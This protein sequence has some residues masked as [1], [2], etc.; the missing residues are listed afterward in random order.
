MGNKKSELYDGKHTIMFNEEKHAY[1][2]EQSGLPVDGVTSILKVLNKPA[3]GPWMVKVDVGEFRRLIT[4][5]IETEDGPLSWKEF[6]ENIPNW[7]KL[8]KQKHRTISKEAT[9]IGSTVHAFAE[10]WLNGRKTKLPEDKQARQGCKAFLEWTEAH[11]IEPIFVERVCFNPDYWYCG[12]VDY[13]GFI[14]DEL[15]VLDFKTSKD[16][17]LE[18]ILQLCAY[19]V[20]LEKE[21]E[22]EIR[23]GWI[24]RLDKETGACTAYKIELTTGF[25]DAW[26]RVR[27]SE[28]HISKLQETEYAIRKQAKSAATV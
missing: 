20:A 6:L 4:E 16:F 10:D 23:V 25:K 1:I 17:Y 28:D 12:T 24:V 8:A 21:F 18:M 26:L 13:Y 27:E 19:A 14:D 5:W 2:H 15:C 22:R 7:E 11:K 3:I 9:D